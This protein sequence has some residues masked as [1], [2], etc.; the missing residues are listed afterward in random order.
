MGRYIGDFS[1][2]ADERP[3]AVLQKLLEQVKEAQGVRYENAILKAALGAGTPDEMRSNVQGAV[4]QPAQGLLARLLNPFNPAGNYNGPMPQRAA[5]VMGGVMADTMQY[6]GMSPGARERAR[7]IQMGLE[8][9]AGRAGE[10]SGFNLSPGQ[11]R[12]DAAGNRIASLPATTERGGPVVRNIIEGEG[13]VSAQYNEKT[14][15]WDPVLVALGAKDRFADAMKGL[16][17]EH[18]SGLDWA[19]NEKAYNTGRRRYIRRSVDESGMEPEAAGQE[20]DQQWRERYEAEKGDWFEKYGDPA[21]IPSFGAGAGQAGPGQR[22]APSAVQGAAAEDRRFTETVRLVAAIRNAIA[23]DPSLVRN[24]QERGD[25]EA[26]IADGNPED[27]AL[28]VRQ[29]G[30]N[31]PQRGTAR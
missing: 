27:L 8:P 16:D 7:R 28:L 18:R 3:A 23:A 5:S 21:G 4:Q 25:I 10:M 17:T 22:G 20:F 2:P 31:V 29:M 30:L 12:F 19:Y 14:G 6:G 15:T 1:Q 24:E 11:A 26:R 13:S 9:S